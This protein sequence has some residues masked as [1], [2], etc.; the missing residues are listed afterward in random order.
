MI[1]LLQNLK[2]TSKCVLVHL[3]VLR[4]LRCSNAELHNKI[5]GNLKRNNNE[6]KHRD[7]QHRRKIQFEVGYQVLSHLRKESF[8]RGTYNKL[9][10]KKIGPCKILWKFGENAYEIELPKDVG[11]SPIFKI[12]YLYNYREGGTRGS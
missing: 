10:L 2:F 12:E 5:K 11:I 8:P 9:K 3:V 6:Y 7:D 1:H 4:R